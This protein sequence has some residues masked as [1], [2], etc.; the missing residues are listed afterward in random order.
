M[1]EKMK[2]FYDLKGK[3][4][5]IT[6]GARRIGRVI[7]LSLAAQG[8]NIIIHYNTSGQYAEYLADE[9]RKLG[10]KYY[11]LQADLEQQ[12]DVDSL[13]DRA[14]NLSGGFQILINNASIFSQDKL[15]SV[16]FENISTNV[17]VNAWAPLAVSRRFV[18]K[19]QGGKIINLLDTR[20]QEINP[21]WHFSYLLSKKMFKTITKMMALEYAP[22]YMVNGVAPG[23]ILPPHGK[24]ISYIEKLKD[25]V[26][27]QRIGDPLQV[28][29][30]VVFLLKNNFIT[31][32][33]VA[34][35][36][37]RNLKNGIDI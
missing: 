15:S 19:G 36:G 13:A 24:D 20:T 32:Q 2:L 6:G 37:G 4:A 11:L 34:V 18:K 7:A 30:T 16:S 27:L 5:L 12:D 26:P 22:D 28:A 1:K 23:L 10:V 35:D 31:G 33:V 14:W 8:V 9:I 3:T 29:E 21:N 17:M 25:T